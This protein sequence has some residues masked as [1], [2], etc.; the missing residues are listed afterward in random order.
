MKNLRTAALCVSISLYSLSSVA[1]TGDIPI[2]EPNLNKPKLFQNLPDIIPVKMNNIT[3]LMGAEVGRPVSLSLSD[4]TVFQFEGIIVSSVSKYEN[5]IQSIV[6]RST[7]FP[8]ATLTVSRITDD[9]GNISYIG[10]M[11][12]MQHGDM[13]ELKNENSQFLLVK[14]KFYDLVNE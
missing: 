14:R 1:Q 10:R 8:G 12:S 4:A 7:N 5:T 11:L 9:T 3:V 2:N 6:I 13:F